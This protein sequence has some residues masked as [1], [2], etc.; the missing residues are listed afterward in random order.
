MLQAGEFSIPEIRAE[1]D[2]YDSDHCSIEIDRFFQILDEDENSDPS[3]RHSPNS[4]EGLQCE[5]FGPSEHY[6][7]AVKHD[8]DSP[9]Q[10]GMQQAMGIPSVEVGVLGSILQ[11]SAYFGAYDSMARDESDRLYELP[12]SQIFPNWKL[13]Q[14]KLDT[15]SQT[16][17]KYSL[18]SDPFALQSDWLALSSSGH[19]NCFFD[20]AT[21]STNTVTSSSVDNRYLQNRAQGW[22]TQSEIAFGV[23]N[24]FSDC[25]N[26]VKINYMDCKRENGF[27]HMKD[28]SSNQLEVKSE[29]VMNLPPLSCYSMLQRKDEGSSNATLVDESCLGDGT[30]HAGGVAS[31]GAPLGNRCTYNFEV[32]SI[33]SAVSLPVSPSAEVHG[34]QMT[35]IMC[36]ASRHPPVSYCEGFTTDGVDA[37]FADYA[38]E[39]LLFG[40]YHQQSV[41]SNEQT[42]PSIKNERQDQLLIPHSMCS[43]SDLNLGVQERTLG[44]SQSVAYLMNTDVPEICYAELNGHQ[45]NGFKCEGSEHSSLM[46]ITRNC[47]SDADDGNSTCR[48]SW[49]VFPDCRPFNPHKDM[50]SIKDGKQNKLLSSHSTFTHAVI[51][52]DEAVDK[53][54][55]RDGSYDDSD[56]DICILEDMSDPRCQP[57]IA[58]RGKHHPYT[59]RSTFI[60]PLHHPGVAGTRLR[61][62][63]ER[64]TFHVALQDLSQTKSEASP[65]DG[66]LAVPLLRHQRIALSWMVQKET[67][68]FHCS[69]GILA[70]DQGLGKTVSTIAL[71]LMEKPP[72]AKLIPKVVEQAEI[73]ALNLDDDD[74]NG[75][76]GGSV[77]ITINKGPT[78]SKNSFVAG[79]G[80]PAAGTLVVC[81]TSVLRQ[82]AEE[83]QNKVSREANLS[84]LVYHGSHRTRDPAELAKHDVVITTY[85]IVSM[86]VPKQPLDDQDDEEKIKLGADDLSVV[87]TNRKRK[88]PPSKKSSKNKKGMDGPL[89]ESTAR[90]LARVGWFRVVLDEAQSIKNH[91]TQVARACWGLRAKR[92]WCLSGTPIQN[93]VDDLYS[94]FRFLRYDP[95]AVYKSFCSNIKVPIHK[96]PTNGYKKL[97]AV[98]KTVMLRRTKG[99]LIDGMPIIN[100]PPKFVSLKKVDFSD[101]ERNFY[102]RL[103]ADS[104][105]QFKVYAAAGTV[106]Q[107]YVNILLML[108][109]LRQACDHPLLVKGYDS[110]SVWRSSVETARK[111]PR[112]KQIHLLNCLEACLAICSICN[113]PPEDAVV[114]ICGHVFCNQCI[115]EHLT[116]DD[117]L[118]PVT[119]CKVQ[120]GVTCVFSKA[121]LKS[122]LSDQLGHD[123]SLD[124]TELVRTPELCTE[125]LPA[126]SSKIKAALQ[127]LESVSK[128]KHSTYDNTKPFDDFSSYSGSNYSLGE[129]SNT[130]DKIHSNMGNGSS[131]PVAEKAIVFSQWTRMLDLLEARLKNSSIQYRRLDGTMSVVA[132]DRAVKDFNTL[133]EVS[134][135]I[136]SLKAASL[137]LNMVAACHVLLLDLWWNPTTEDQA[138]DRAHRIGQTRPVTVSRLTVKDTVEDRILALQE[139]KREMVA[140]A[141][142]EDETG[143][144]QTRLT[145]EDLEYLFMA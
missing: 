81:P 78:E 135:M 82:W 8:K 13:D 17:G 110:N 109:R 5:N 25:T 10:D 51:D 116:G 127:I 30:M 22:N 1:G 119:H 90:P 139:R 76:H 126:D 108:L 71:I 96:N 54:L 120:L 3:A 136:M 97:Q 7:A 19:N 15:S 107:N 62:N 29:T 64:L 58:D 115:C 121:T 6:S 4:L 122:S 92:R 111:L 134:V 11:P 74:D 131:A 103:E 2:F 24:Y 49:K 87:T 88:N 65:P 84:V 75:V 138:I 145:V 18:R 141:F 38:S 83:L 57:L 114:T 32:A 124:S 44:V 113:D 93:A 105:A 37:S 46:S 45:D 73:N 91:R 144:R 66:V 21:P 102:S 104:R 117:N 23:A 72:T 118:C 95:Y 42:V 33:E 100:L 125:F 56:T 9:P 59:Q 106:K 63:D 26:S 89:L 47:S 69:G 129:E 12:G 43:S 112:E 14:E 48:A 35:D 41:P 40:T 16:N 67:A 70:D 99:T 27:K 128:P 123:C 94:Y 20:S 36:E 86:E 140:S 133:P 80:R 50:V 53:S 68:S 142:G 60:E 55:S 143:S 34:G 79:N 132:R 39:H 101:E 61:A 52:T 130:H 77:N 137:G 31:S 98:L 28:R 85:S